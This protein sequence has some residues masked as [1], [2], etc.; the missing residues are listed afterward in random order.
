MSRAAQRRLC[1][2]SG[3]RV[4]APPAPPAP[5]GPRPRGGARHFAAA[6]P[7]AQ[8]PEGLLI[9]PKRVAFRSINMQN[10]S[11][12]SHS[13]APRGAGSPGICYAARSRPPPRV[14]LGKWKS[15]CAQ[16][17]PAAPPR[18]GP[19][20]PTSARRLESLQA[21]VPEFMLTKPKWPLAKPKGQARGAEQG[22]E[23]WMDQCW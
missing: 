15:G 9:V 18:P 13:R 17:R 22:V 6:R 19:P 4:R 3:G 11:K 21:G 12:S 5:P 8:A 23:D 14:Y 2:R 1:A 16:S 10:R 7:A 20:P